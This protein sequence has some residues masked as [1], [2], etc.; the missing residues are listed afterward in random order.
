MFGSLGLRLADDMILP[1][2][3]VDYAEALQSYIEG[4]QK[5]F[6]SNIDFTPMI[7]AVAEF[8]NAAIA[9]RSQINGIDRDSVSD[10]GDSH[11]LILIF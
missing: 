4:Y 2:D 9:I 10:V 8:K 3:F 11:C 6:G 1:Y 5:E 7:S